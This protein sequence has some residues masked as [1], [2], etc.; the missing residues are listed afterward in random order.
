MPP[1]RAVRLL[2]SQE[3]NGE[4]VLDDMRAYADAH[5]VQDMLQLL[6][7]RLLEAQPMDPFEFLID[8]VQHDPAL[9]ALEEK[10]RLQ[11]YDLR[12]EKTKRALVE[13]FFKR[14]VVLQRTQYGDKREL[15]ADLASRFLIEQLKLD[16]TRR[17]LRTLFPR[18]Y[19]DLIQWFVTREKELGSALTLHH[20]TTSCMQVL[21]TLAMA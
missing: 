12:R 4:Q 11:R 6:L 9:D 8:A 17:H 3:P 21:A 7:A 14:L 2:S 18:H 16:E 15:G 13:A 20:F 10:A 5:Q 19:R 1:A